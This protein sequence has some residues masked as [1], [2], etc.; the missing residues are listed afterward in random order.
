MKKL[1]FAAL[2]AAA[3]LWAAP[4]MA[5][6][7]TYEV[8]W[9][10]V[11]SVGG[12][13]TPDGSQGAGGGTVNGTYETT[14]DDGS[15]VNGTVRCVGMRQPPS[16]MFAIHLSCTAK[17]DQGTYSLIYGCNFLGEP[18]PETPL[19][20]VGGMQAKDGENAGA[21]GNLTMHWYSDEKSVGT[22]QWY[23]ATAE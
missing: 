15:V 18:G 23:T 4:A 1:A 6:S 7:F 13:T 9:E 17:D 8:T 11:E 12:I 10:P 14:F 5:Q 2:G 3:T 20:C 22:G 21:R 19:G 16:G